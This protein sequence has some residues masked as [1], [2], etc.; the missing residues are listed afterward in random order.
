MRHVDRHV[1]RLDLRIGKDLF[2]RL[3]L[4]GG[5][6]RAVEPDNP[7]FARVAGQRRI[8]QPVQFLAPG[9]ALVVAVKARIGQQV[10]QADLGQEPSQHLIVGGGNG[11]L[12]VGGIIKPVRRHQRMIVAGALRVLA[13]DKMLG[14]KIG[15]HAQHAIDH[16]GFHR[17]PRPVA[18]AAMQRRDDAESGVKPR[19]Q[20]GDRL[21]R[22]Q[23]RLVGGAVHAHEPAHRLRDEVKGG[24]VDIGPGGAEAVDA[25]HDQPG[26]EAVQFLLREAHPRQHAGAEVFDQHVGGFQKPG[27][28]LPPLVGI[29]IQHH[30]FLVAVE[31]RE[32]PRKAVLVMALPAHRIACGAFDLDDLRPHIPQQHGTE[33]PGQHAGQVDHP[34]PVQRRLHP[35][36]HGHAASP[37]EERTASR[38]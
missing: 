37:R 5:H 2:Q 15:H 24:P 3:D 10:G 17:L 18:V 16:G 28:R 34:D 38:P 8:Q 33:R 27:Q 12:P 25:G 23:R 36:R 20:I 11:D 13:G 22:A 1:L 29:K 6:A 14:G 32:I 9:E 4:A 19:H 21:G 7:V 35:R 31:A 26:I 30:G